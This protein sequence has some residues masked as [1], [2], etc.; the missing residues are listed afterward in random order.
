MDLTRENQQRNEFRN[1][2]LDLAKSQDILQESSNRFAMYKRLEALYDASDNE[3]RFRHFYSDIFAVLTEIQRNTDLGSIDVLAQNLDE[4]RR[5]YQ[6]KTVQDGRLIDVSDAIN[7]LYDHVNLDVARIN[8][9]DSLF[10]TMSGEATVEQMKAELNSVNFGYQDIEQKVQNVEKKLDSS[11]KEYISILG[12][13]AAVV[14]AFTGGMAF[15]TSV[16][17]NIAQASIYRTVLISLVIGL[18]LV[19]TIFGL[20]YYVNTI[21]AKDKSLKPLF[22]SNAVIVILLLF[23]LAAWAFG[24]VERRNSCVSTIVPLESVE[25]ITETNAPECTPESFDFNDEA[26]S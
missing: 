12:I 22:I 23:T 25:P 21:V 26:G 10:H 5:G 14:L 18:V 8:Y 7:K 11:Q 20:F 1:L 24:V 6:A 13:F 3:K 9:S 2:M 17:N 16:L 19:N 15:S 4:I